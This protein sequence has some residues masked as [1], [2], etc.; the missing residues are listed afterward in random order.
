MCKNTLTLSSWEDSGEFL[1][2]VRDSG[3]PKDET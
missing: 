1:T 2:C 3:N